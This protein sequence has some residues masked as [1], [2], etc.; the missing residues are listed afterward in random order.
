MFQRFSILARMAILLTM[1][2][3]SAPVRP[4]DQPVADPLSSWNGKTKQDILAFVKKV[5][6]KSGRDYVPPAERI[7]VFDNDGTLWSE[8]PM[9]F[10]LA[11]ALDRVKAAAPKHPEWKEQQPFKAVLEGDMKAIA[12]SGEK[13]LIELLLA[14]HAG[15]T[16]DEFETIVKDWLAYIV[17]GGGV[18][19]MRTFAEKV[20]GIP[21][22]QVIGSRIKHKY[23]LRKNG[24]VLIRLAG[25]DFIDDGP[26]KP[27]GIFNIIGRMPI[28][29]FGNSDGD[30]EMLEWTAA[31]KGASFMGIVHHTDDVREY[32][33]DRTSHFGRLDTA[34][35]EGRAR[36]WSI[37]D[38]KSDWKVIYPFEK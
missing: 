2:F 32:A 8:Q 29:A 11:F 20:Y 34:L 23:E 5:S 21:P 36:G 28:F 24:P 33:Y 6:D 16:T 30:K 25:V 37:V 9:Y 1:C 27:I 14:T 26:D 15:M 13:G 17:S 31:R 18:E 38:M 35:D 19:F 22:E 7:A 3:A 12:A 10:Q 4:Q